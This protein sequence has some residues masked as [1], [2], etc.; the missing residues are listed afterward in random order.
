MSELEFNCKSIQEIQYYF[1]SLKKEFE[2]YAAALHNIAKESDSM[3]LT[4]N[5]EDEELGALLSIINEIVNISRDMFGLSAAMQSV[6]T[7]SDEIS[8]IY[9]TAESLVKENFMSV[10]LFD[11]D[12]HDISVN[13]SFPIQTNDSTGN[14]EDTRINET[15]N[16]DLPIQTNNKT[17][18]YEDSRVNESTSNGLPTDEKNAGMKDD[19]NIPMPIIT[20]S[21][22]GVEKYDPLEKL[23][24][25]VKNIF[26]KPDFQSGMLSSLNGGD[27]NKESFL[28]WI[29]VVFPNGIPWE[30]YVPLM[31]SQLD[32]GYIYLPFKNL[33]FDWWQ[34]FVS[35]KTGN[36]NMEKENGNGNG[37][38]NN[39]GNSKSENGNGQISHPPASGEDNSYPAFGT[40]T[41]GKQNDENENGSGVLNNSGNGKSEN[42][43]GQISQPSANGENNSYPVS[44]TG[45]GGKQSDEVSNN[46]INYGLNGSFENEKNNDIFKNLVHTAVAGAGMS[47]IG[48]ISTETF[49]NLVGNGVAD[50]DLN[51][52]KSK[53]ISDEASKGISDGAGKGIS[54]EASKVVYDGANESIYDETSNGVSDG[55]SENAGILGEYTPILSS[56]D[57]S[58]LNMPAIMGTG[59]SGII[60]LPIPLNEYN[61]EF[62]STKRNNGLRSDLSAFAGIMKDSYA[63][64]DVIPDYDNVG[65]QEFINGNINENINENGMGALN[66]E[67]AHILNEQIEQIKYV[68]DSDE[69]ENVKNKIEQTSMNSDDS[70]RNNI[71]DMTVM[72]ENITKEQVPK[73]LN[74]L[75]FG[76]SI[77]GAVAVTAAEGGILAGSVAGSA[78]ANRNNKDDG[79]YDPENNFK[80]NAVSAPSVFAGVLDGEY[81]I[82]GTAISMLFCG[83]TFA[84]GIMRKEKIKKPGFRTGDGV[85]VIISG[86]VIQDKY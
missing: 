70:I 84:A 43:N 1:S 19:N 27:Y 77:A 80:I 25:W 4:V 46:N 29:K 52:D 47:S 17:D 48:S 72:A 6:E 39:S 54:D 75:L 45:T 24:E 59:I 20:P 23:W 28:E 38:K 10:N 83:T 40:G 34:K 41:G 8:D 35:D 11:F 12:W 79:E 15:T 32:Y 26:D 67:K 7:A 62:I 22:P 30:I 81:Y 68:N 16:N 55:A 73:G 86:G 60:S 37:I 53:N 74:P 9:Y 58:S 44:G 61:Q 33:V 66:G 50:K 85:S 31:V 49:A 64:P 57:I 76:S 82:L 42:G 51:K 13:N 56:N 5:S 2:D 36:K 63:T 21:I 71:S 78:N 3:S 69:I 14:Y 18:N 65:N